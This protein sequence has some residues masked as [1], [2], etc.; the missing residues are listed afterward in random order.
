MDRG[1]WIEASF[2]EVKSKYLYD[3]NELHHMWRAFMRHWLVNG[4]GGLAGFLF[5]LYQR[6]KTELISDL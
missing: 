2:F 1:L 5:L 3:S 4:H 6:N